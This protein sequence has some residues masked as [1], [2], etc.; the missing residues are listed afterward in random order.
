MKVHSKDTIKK[1][2]A[3]TLAVAMLGT[4]FSISDWQPSTLQAKCKEMTETDYLN[5]L[6]DL[7]RSYVYR[8]GAEKHTASIVDDKNNL[9]QENVSKLWYTGAQL[10]KLSGFSKSKT[11]N[12]ED[13][14][15]YTYFYAPSDTNNA[16][17]C[18]ETAYVDTNGKK[19]F[20]YIYEG[21][22]YGYQIARISL[23]STESLKAGETIEYAGCVY[24][25]VNVHI[26]DTTATELKLPAYIPNV[27][28]HKLENGGLARRL[29]DE[30]YNLP[31]VE[32]ADYGFANCQSVKKIVVPASYQR[33]CNHACM[34]MQALEQ[35]VYLD[36]AG[37]AG[38]GTTI[39]M[40]GDHAFA[41]CSN[42][43]EATLPKE[44]IAG[45]V[46]SHGKFV[47]MSDTRFAN[48][49]I[50]YSG[51]SP[52]YMG[53]GVYQDCDSI[54]SVS[55]AGEYPYVPRDTFAGCKGLAEVHFSEKIKTLL[56]DLSCFAGEINCGNQIEELHIP[57]DVIMGGYAFTNCTNLKRVE[58][59]GTLNQNVNLNG[60]VFECSG[61][62]FENSFAENGEFIYNPNKLGTKDETQDKYTLTV[63]KEC[64]LRT[65]GL[66]KFIIGTEKKADSNVDVVLTEGAF[67]SSNIK[68]LEFKGGSYTVHSG[69]L[70]QMQSTE[71][72]TFSNTGDVRLC[73]EPFA[74]SYHS[75]G[76]DLKNQSK[77]F[78]KLKG[79]RFNNT[80]N[81]EVVH[82]DGGTVWLCSDNVYCI[83]S[84]TGAWQQPSKASFYGLPEVDVYFGKEVAYILSDGTDGTM[85]DF[86][87]KNNGTET[88][89]HAAFGDVKAIYLQ[90]PDVSF[91]ARDYDVT[92]SVFGDGKRAF[93][94][95]SVKIYGIPY[96]TKDR[97]INDFGMLLENQK[98]YKNVEYLNYYND[99]SVEVNKNFTAGKGFD[100]AAITVQAICADRTKVEI[101]YDPQNTSAGYILDKSTQEAFQADTGAGMDFQLGVSYLGKSACV[102]AHINEKQLEK[103]EVQIKEGTE[104]I[105]NTRP[106]ASDFQLISGTYDN[107]S[108]L[109]PE[110]LEKANLTV[111]L[112]SGNTV[113]GAPGKEEI[114]ISYDT[115]STVTTVAVRAKK[116]VSMSAV[117]IEPIYEGEVLRASAFQVKAAYDNG[118]IDDKYTKYTMVPTMVAYEQT[119]VTLTGEDGCTLQVPITVTE[120][121]GIEVQ[122]KQENGETTKFT[123]FETINKENLFVILMYGNN[124][125]KVL[126]PSEYTITLKKNEAGKEWLVFTPVNCKR[127]HASYQSDL[128]IQNADEQVEETTTSSTQ[129]P[130]ASPV[131][132]DSVKAGGEEI[133]APQTSPSHLPQDSAGNDDLVLDRVV[134]EGEVTTSSSVRDNS[135]VASV[136]AETTPIQ[137]PI[138]FASNT[139]IPLAAAP[140]VTSNNRKLKVSKITVGL[141]E[142]VTFALSEGKLVTGVAQN[143][144]VAKIQKNGRVY[145]N[146]VGTTNIS[147]KDELGNVYSA[148]LVVKNAPKKVTIKGKKTLKVKKKM[149]LK[150][151]LSKNSAS[152]KNT[153]RSSKKQVATVSATGL[154][155]AKRKGVT[156]ITVT[157]YNGCKAKIKVKVK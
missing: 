101:P 65:K 153:Y 156:T 123:S 13:N 104:F 87:R 109:T 126:E 82:R 117:Q 140:S 99:I 24:V 74:F 112:V 110:Q 67:R 34:N 37:K 147:W 44:W 33:L 39:H 6:N 119:S 32:I 18:E 157:T 137:Y 27:K 1:C 43:K 22:T 145:A 88:F 62:I 105:E 131:A 142:S 72:I 11:C 47:Q 60:F 14:K 111:R 155:T 90:N 54:Q 106:Q 61:N 55:I 151:V 143:T 93:N 70:S 17:A 42:L 35:V 83:D 127:V 9:D 116:V 4:G 29:V 30:T 98:Q 130:A 40:I 15:T 71:W 92:S 76:V 152:H 20:S 59:N 128:L 146:G 52:Y 51:Y 41:G 53:I 45:I 134:S 121:T 31:C 107:G 50:R 10:K 94:G 3:T 56:L 2:I 100:P 36:D 80:S 64:F 125:Y 23:A 16:Y 38:D 113:F 79:V 25:A 150:L 132:T 77:G 138:A 95:E 66:Q 97:T 75:I 136:T 144:K 84:S 68:N 154:V 73:G 5:N 78:G 91:M 26:H 28:L 89:R 115:A 49:T 8:N 124:S 133:T 19:E 139:A 148:Q 141:H 102:M 63:P 149:Q 108:K 103:I 57:C 114:M 122:F 46:D 120:V 58:L 69:A 135:V 129:V 12:L 81:N 86:E 21:V 48:G 118:Y 7:K 96:V 85:M